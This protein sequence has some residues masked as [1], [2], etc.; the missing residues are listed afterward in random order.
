MLLNYPGEVNEKHIQEEH[1]DGR[2]EGEVC[3]EAKEGNSTITKP[4]TQKPSSTSC[5]FRCFKVP[6]QNHV[7]VS[8][9]RALNL[10]ILTLI[11]VNKLLYD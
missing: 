2:R 7:E 4:E 8:V 1:N 6:L 9:S 5:A 11:Q 3:G 10:V